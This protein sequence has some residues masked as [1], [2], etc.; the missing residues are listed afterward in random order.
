M[1]YIFTNVGNASNIY[2]EKFKWIDYIPVD[3]VRAEKMTTG[4]W[5]QDLSYSVLYKTNKSQEYILFKENLQTTED[6]ELDFT[7]LELTQD[8]CITEICYDFGRVDV[9]FKE[10][11]APTMKCKSLE[12]LQDGE[13]FTNYTKTIGTY[14]E[15]IAEAEDKWTT[16]VHK[17][18]EEHPPVLPRTGE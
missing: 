1:E 8:E 12:T 4:T 5:N 7:K 14:F 10:I 11:T 3:Y 17:P 18:K 13:S 6:S 15:L 2:L 9:G 16:I